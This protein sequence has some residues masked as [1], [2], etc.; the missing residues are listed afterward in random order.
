MGSSPGR[1]QCGVLGQGSL[2]LN[3]LARCINGYSSEKNV[4]LGVTLLLV[5][6]C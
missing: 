1:A 6:S 3:S 4:M 5:S 2:H